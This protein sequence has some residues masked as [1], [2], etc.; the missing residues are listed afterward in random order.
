MVAAAA[1]PP[2]WKAREY[3]GTEAAATLTLSY[4]AEAPLSRE[5]NWESG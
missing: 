5:A 3:G 1:A 2:N 4:P